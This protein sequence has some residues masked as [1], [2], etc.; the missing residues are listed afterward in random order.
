MKGKLTL[1]VWMAVAAGM[2]VVATAGPA[3]ADE[4]I[5]V[6][7]PFDFIV[8]DVRLPAGDYVVTEMSV[9]S[10]VSIAS[11]DG[12]H[13]AFVLTIPSSSDETAPLP[14]VVFERFGGE[15]FLS[16]ITGGDISGREVPL[17]PASMERELHAVAIAEDR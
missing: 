16:R 2:I 6:T 8:A 12:Q 13:F 11:T 9:P 3:R 14:E 1:K 5:T 17:T 10:V 15:H 7:V 4:Q